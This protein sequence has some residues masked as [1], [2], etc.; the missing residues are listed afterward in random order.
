MPFLTFCNNDISNP[1]CYS[2]HS[3]YK[4]ASL[5]SDSQE[6]AAK[7]AAAKAAKDAYEAKF[8][9]CSEDVKAA[10]E[11]AA[12]AAAAVAKSKK[13]VSENSIWYCFISL[14]IILFGIVCDVLDHSF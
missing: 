10:Q 6:Q 11:L 5:F 1:I 8:A 14:M 3:W 9:N 2:T 12:A 4:V 7:E 13:V